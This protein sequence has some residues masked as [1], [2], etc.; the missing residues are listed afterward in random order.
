ME[1]QDLTPELAKQLEFK[2]E[3]GVVVTDVHAGSA[4]E[5]AGLATGMVIVE[6]AHRPVGSAAE[7]TKMLTDKSLADGVLLLVRRRKAAAT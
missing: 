1:V 4:A 5:R 6:A 7:L 2:A 3:H